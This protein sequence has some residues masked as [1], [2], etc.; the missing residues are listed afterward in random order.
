MLV[1]GSAARLAVLS[2]ATSLPSAATWSL[3]KPA[4]LA[5]CKSDTATPPRKA[6]PVP[7]AARSAADRPLELLPSAAIWALLS[8]ANR[9]LPSA[10]M[11]AELK[12]P[13]RLP[14]PAIPESPNAAT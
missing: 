7:S 14:R 5:A 13:N 1:P 3:V 6:T 12:A 11:S 8:S 2:S 10:A 9:A 4:M